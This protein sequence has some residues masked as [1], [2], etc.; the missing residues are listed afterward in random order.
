M[1]RSARR[2]KRI[3]F[4]FLFIFLLLFCVSSWKRE[5]PNQRRRFPYFHDSTQGLRPRWVTT[6]RRGKLEKWKTR[7]ENDPLASERRKVSLMTMGEEGEGGTEMCRFSS[8]SWAGVQGSRA[9]PGRLQ[10]RSSGGLGRFVTES[11]SHPGL[12][13]SGRHPV[14]ASGEP[15][16]R[17]GPRWQSA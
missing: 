16:L 9:A 14:T 12:R 13:A 1:A 8:S 17:R 2:G 15:P 5:R 6:T 11:Q 10:A 3:I 7:V 4:L